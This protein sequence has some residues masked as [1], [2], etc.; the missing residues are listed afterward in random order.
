M[1]HVR[2]CICACAGEDYGHPNGAWTSASG[3]WCTSGACMRAHATVT[4][5]DRCTVM[6][7][8]DP[9]SP[10]SLLSRAVPFRSTDCLRAVQLVIG[11]YT[12]ACTDC[13]RS[14]TRLH[15]VPT[16]HPR[17]WC[18]TPLTHVYTHARSPRTGT[19]CWPRCDVS[20]DEDYRV[21]MVHGRVRVG[22]GA[23]AV[24]LSSPIVARPPMSQ[25]MHPC[26]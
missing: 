10:V 21:L 12:D 16:Q 11:Q 19:L 14:S 13:T 5:P 2:A 20:A 4:W 24:L 22:H 23:Q 1:V 3:S 17:T 7:H 18:R 6:M 25:C 15:S 26:Q 9:N 8:T